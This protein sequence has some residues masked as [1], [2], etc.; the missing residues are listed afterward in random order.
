MVSIQHLTVRYGRLTAVDDLS[1]DVPAGELFGLLGSNGA[2]KTTTLKVLAGLLLPHA[3]SVRVLGLNVITDRLA[4]QRSAGYMADFFGVYDY[5]TVDEYLGCFAGLYAVRPAER[6]AR[7]ADLLRL[8]RLESKR[9]ALVKQL[10]RGMRQRLYF[11][12]ALVHDPALLILDEPAS[13]LDPRGRAEMADLLRRLHARGKT[14]IISSHILGELE[15]LCTSVGVLERGRLVGGGPLGDTTVPAGTRRVTVEV[16]AGDVN[17]ALACLRVQA[18][19]RR[20]DARGNRLDIEVR[21]DDDTVSNLVTALVGAGVHILLPSTESRDLQTM[22][23][24]MT[25]GE[26]M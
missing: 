19:V 14:I 10:S 13:G 15:G 2:G 8:T 24:N 17:A 1:L 6:A 21:D 4:V 18:G 16:R 25:R 11:A 20:T 12:R 26:L 3:G 22:F 5:L 23:L 7:L 9:D